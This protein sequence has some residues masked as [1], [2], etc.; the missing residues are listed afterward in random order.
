M[1]TGPARRIVHVFE[2]GVIGGQFRVVEALSLAQR[3]AGLDPIILAVVNSDDAAVHPTLRSMEDGGVDVIRIRPP[4]PRAYLAERRE[5]IR[6]T[7]MAGAD[8]VHTHGYR[9][10]VVDAPGTRRAGIA[11]ICTLHGFTGGSRQNRMY[12]FLQ[13]W[14]ARRLDAAVV[15]SEPMRRQMLE[16]GFPN[17]ILHVVPNTVV[18]APELL[19]KEHA[20][21]R[22]QLGSG[23]HVGWI[24]R[25]STEKGPDVLIE[26][27]ASMGDPPDCTSFVGSGPMHARLQARSEVAG[28]P[29]R[30]HGVVQNAESYLRA[31]D[32]VVLSSRS[33]GTPMVLLEA[34][35]ARVPVVATRVGGIPDVV[36]DR[37]A[38]LV[39]P[40]DPAALAA[41]IAEVRRVPSDA[42]T[43]AA[44]ARARLEREFRPE[45]WVEGY[46]EVY[47]QAMKR[48][49][50]A[51]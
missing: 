47:R 18:P 34:I 32:C 36:S 29:V 49:A 40:D 33:E 24:G 6:R 7:R 27:V 22:L 51:R 11:T 8:V 31:F 42:A 19:S 30:W 41:A 14:V 9:A 5:V 50:G 17:D 28:L 2:M 13:R 21:Q 1:T 16:D 45:R 4:G 48:R 43:R 15:V 3:Q 25:I 10:D 44:A 35:A 23:F 38:F 37:E 12:E 20:R 26:A 46:Q 39:A